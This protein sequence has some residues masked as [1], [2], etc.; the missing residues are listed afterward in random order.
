M[1][2]SILLQQKT[3]NIL[4]YKYL[5]YVR[6]LAIKKKKEISVASLSVPAKQQHVAV[7]NE[8]Y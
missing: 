8:S 7:F 4:S 3:F 1:S 5:L 2:A 6:L